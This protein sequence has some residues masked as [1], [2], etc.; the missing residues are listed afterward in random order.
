MSYREIDKHECDLQDFVE[1]EMTLTPE[2]AA[3]L[4]ELVTALARA[5]A[6]D[7]KDRLFNMGDYRS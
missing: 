2:Q 1:R 7:E 3:T 4:A 6:Q 5:V